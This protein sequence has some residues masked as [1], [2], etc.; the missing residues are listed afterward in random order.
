[1]SHIQLTAKHRPQ[2]FAQVAGQEEIRAILS[3]TAA[4]DRVAAAYLFSGT[5]GVGKTTLARI[6][7]KALNCVTAPAA[8][9]CNKCHHCRQITI[10]S[11][12]DVAE[13]DGA[14]NRGI[15]QARRLKEDVGYAPLECRYKV[16]IIDEAHMLTKE[17]F[18]ALL[19]TMEEPPPRVTFIMAT[20]EP[21]KFPATIISRSQ[22][23]VFK[24]LPQA[25]LQAHLE[26]ILDLEGRVYE[27]AATALLARRAAGSVRDGMSLLEQVLTISDQALRLEDVRRTLGLAGGELFQRLIQAMREQDCLAVH[28]VLGDLLREGLDLGFFLRELAGLWRNLF[29]LR[30][31]GNKALPLLELPEEEGRA[32]L[33]VAADLSPTYIHAAWQITLEAQRKVLTSLEPAQSLEMLLLNLTYL[34]ALVPLDGAFSD[35]PQQAGSVRPVSFS[36]KPSDKSTKQKI[37]VGPEP[38]PTDRSPPP[39]QTWRE[40][41]QQFP[42]SLSETIQGPSEA[43][44]PVQAPKSAPPPPSPPTSPVGPSLRPPTKDEAVEEP[45]TGTRPST[46]EGSEQQLGL[47]GGYPPPAPASARNVQEPRPQ[48]DPN[49]I[50]G[51]E[52]PLQ[53][54]ARTAD[55]AFPVKTL[56]GFLNHYDRLCRADKARY[57]KLRQ[58]ECAMTDQGLVLHC[59]HQVQYDLLSDP[60][61]LRVLED[62]AEDYFERPMRMELVPPRNGGQIPG[63]SSG[64]AITPD[65]HPLVAEFVEQFKAKVVSVEPRQPH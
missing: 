19:K 30:Q 52:S 63:P 40:R 60:H 7:A 58:I 26:R 36:P 10:G 22:H 35:K 28:D 43:D 39:R 56:E 33:A 48:P 51:E 1:M 3:R 9:P 23:Y 13:I 57:P 25:G 45:T 49:F 21:H 50:A 54:S 59:R 6:F 38:I 11:A 15:E 34:P 18:N 27:P 4:Q 42:R 65:K 44:Q 17:A 5:R 61:K 2:T 8:E 16:I 12:P 29:L 47:D 41:S 55:S 46:V 20:T 53:S 31:V 32:W 37:G 14:S 62:A 24:M 64:A